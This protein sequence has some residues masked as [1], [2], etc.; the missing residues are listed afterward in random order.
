MSDGRTYMLKTLSGLRPMSDLYGH[1]NL[2]ED[3]WLSAD[4][5]SRARFSVAPTDR[6]MRLELADGDTAR[7]VCLA[8]REPV[9][10][11]RG[12]GRFGF[13]IHARSEGF[14]ACH[15][16]FRHV[17]PAG[18]EDVFTPHHLL[19]TGGEQEMTAEIPVDS[20][21]LETAQRIEVTLFLHTDHFKAEFLNLASV[22]LD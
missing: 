21:R 15:P 18:H 6:G 12:A 4:P 2:F 8:W 3:F 13:H 22:R 19:F 9:D 16:S 17:R 1:T 10:R 11:W 7:W 20:A 14:F 5:Q